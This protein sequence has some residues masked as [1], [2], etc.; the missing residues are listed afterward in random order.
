MEKIFLHNITENKQN[1]RMKEQKV[2]YEKGRM[3][4]KNTTYQWAFKFFSL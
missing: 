2:A 3:N 4:K 1:G